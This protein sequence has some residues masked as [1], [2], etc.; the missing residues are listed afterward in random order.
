MATT[1]PYAA[2]YSRGASQTRPPARVNP[3]ILRS[4]FLILVVLLLYT[5]AQL[6][7]A[8]VASG[9]LQDLDQMNK[10]ITVAK[11]ERDQLLARSEELKSL[12]SIEGRALERGWRPITSIE[13]VR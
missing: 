10:D 11:I 4:T 7:L 1:I 12:S 3:G 5:L 9:I 13:F 8:S 2:P 6:S